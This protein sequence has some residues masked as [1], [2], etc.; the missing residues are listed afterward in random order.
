[1]ALKLSLKWRNS[2]FQLYYLAESCCGLFTWNGPAW[3]LDSGWRVLCA[4]SAAFAWCG[5]RRVLRTVLYVQCTNSMVWVA[6]A[7]SIVVDMFTL[8]LLFLNYFRPKMSTGALWNYWGFLPILTMFN[9]C[10]LSIDYCSL[11]LLLLW[12][13]LLGQLMNTLIH[14]C[15]TMD[16][17]TLN[18]DS[19]RKTPPL[20]NGKNVCDGSKKMCT[21]KAIVKISKHSLR[22]EINLQP[23][24]NHISFPDLLKKAK[25]E[26]AL[27]KAKSQKTNDCPIQIDDPVW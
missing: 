3:S 27:A 12:I 4:Y 5:N 8:L 19:K 22:I 10:F 13:N 7:L 16:T 14:P 24:F 9:Y 20:T 21:E 6:S 2:C 15:P 26:K 23:G 18:A 1:M 17:A 11:F 25:T